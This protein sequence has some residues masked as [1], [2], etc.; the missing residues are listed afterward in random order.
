MS[1]EDNHM[2]LEIDEMLLPKFVF[3][4]DPAQGKLIEKEYNFN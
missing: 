1:N 2:A 3:G 4:V